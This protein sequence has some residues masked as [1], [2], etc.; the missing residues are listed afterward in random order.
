[1]SPNKTIEGFYG[2]II[3]PFLTALLFK[4]LQDYQIVDFIDKV[5]SNSFLWMSIIIAIGS[6]SGDFCESFIKRVSKVKDSSNLLPGHGGL[7]DRI[8]SMGLSLP[9]YFIYIKYYVGLNNL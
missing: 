6:V 1:M 9:S 2:A 5:D 3:L 7:L 4:V 8:D